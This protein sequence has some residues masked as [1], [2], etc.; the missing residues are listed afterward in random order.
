MP[1]CISIATQIIDTMGLPGTSISSNNGE[2]TNILAS[3]AQTQL[4]RLD[5]HLYADNSFIVLAVSAFF[6]GAEAQLRK[7]SK[8]SFQRGQIKLISLIKNSLKLNTRTALHLV[9]SVEEYAKRY[10]LIESIVNQGKKQADKWLNCED[11]D[12]SYLEKLVF[13]YQHQNMFDLG[14]DN[15]SIDY[16]KQT[17]KLHLSL[18]KSVKKL[19]TRLVTIVTLWAVLFTA[20]LVYLL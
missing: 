6:F 10:Y 8:I 4:G 13:R 20:L 16:E 15:I 11:T 7:Q 9:L 17:R 14:I 1:I 3:F 12:D 2:E 5:C 18:D 19:R